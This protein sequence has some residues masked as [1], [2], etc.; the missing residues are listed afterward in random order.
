MWGKHLVALELAYNTSFHTALGCSPC[1]AAYG[2][3]P[4]VPL[5]AGLHPPF[6]FQCLHI[7]C[8][9]LKGGSCTGPLGAGPNVA[10]CSS[11]PVQLY[12]PSRSTTKTGC[13]PR[14]STS[15]TSPS[16]NW[17][18][19]V[20]SALKPS[21]LAAM[22]QSVTS[23]PAIPPSGC[24]LLFNP[25]RCKSMRVVHMWQRSLWVKNSNGRAIQW[26]TQTN[27][28]HTFLSSESCGP[29]AIAVWQAWNTAVLTPT[30]K[31]CAA[32]QSYCRQLDAALSVLPHTLP[33]PVPHTPVPPPPAPT[34]PLP[35]PV[36]DLPLPLQLLLLLQPTH[37]G[38]APHPNPFYAP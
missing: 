30:D 4:L 26:T 14:T 36:P 7:E 24:Q 29:T 3:N 22:L 6:P 18:S 21:T 12:K 33:G 8:E 11:Q 10:S 19:L 25:L 15:L 31:N 13:P 20:P 37:S 27:L 35:A 38:Q 5:T 34:P 2:F 23:Q 1:E 28:T 16:S 32:S 17:H 9:L